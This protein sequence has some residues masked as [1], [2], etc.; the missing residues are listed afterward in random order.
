V[1][2]WTVAMFGLA[3]WVFKRHGLDLSEEL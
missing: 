1:L 2:A 3:Y